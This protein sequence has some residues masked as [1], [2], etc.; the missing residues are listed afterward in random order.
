M[1]LHENKLV[2]AKLTRC[3]LLGD[4]ISATRGVAWGFCYSVPTN[5][6][7]RGGKLMLSIASCVKVF[8]PGKRP[9]PI[10][11]DHKTTRPVTELVHKSTSRSSRLQER[12]Y[13]GES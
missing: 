3:G 12:Q 5:V 13:L 9:S 11:R 8:L 4:S 7:P 1:R 2:T 6:Q 10:L